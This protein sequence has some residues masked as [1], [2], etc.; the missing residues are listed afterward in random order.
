VA[1]PKFLYCYKTKKEIYPFDNFLNLGF[2]KGFLA[3]QLFWMISG[4]VIANIYIGGNTS[5]S[6]FM[7]NRFARLYPLHFITLL[8][9]AFLQFICYYFFD[10]TI[11]YP[12]TTRY[13]IENLFSIS[14]ILHPGEQSFNG[15]IWSV[16]VELLAYV[17]FWIIFKIRPNLGF[18]SLFS[19][20]L[21]LFFLIFFQ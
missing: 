5:F 7:R 6:R 16:S 13:F 18:S 19:I 17:I 8:I 14:S 10:K 3:V 1:L 2:Q 20:M 4:F 21:I 11:L 15:P 12:V 9:V